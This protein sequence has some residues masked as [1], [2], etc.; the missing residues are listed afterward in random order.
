MLYKQT[1]KH[2]YPLK[3]NHTDEFPS[4]KLR[5]PIINAVQ[6]AVVRKYSIANKLG[7]IIAHLRL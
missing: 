6:S 7:L 1:I 5:L 2:C 3:E 4:Q